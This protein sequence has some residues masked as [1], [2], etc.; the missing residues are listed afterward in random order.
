ME[1]ESLAAQLSAARRNGG[2]IEVSA[3]A[4]TLDLAAAYKVQ[5]RLLQI[6][7]ERP[8]GYKIGAT[9]EV[10]M[11]LLQ[12]REPFHGP[13]LEPHCHRSGDQL[14]MPTEQQVLVEA[15]IA[16]QLGADLPPSSKGYTVEQV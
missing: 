16:V 4:S 10:S 13:L 1:V 12:L 11:E 7:D 14:S 6:S 15:E 9:T 5:Q 3:V 8:I 2:R